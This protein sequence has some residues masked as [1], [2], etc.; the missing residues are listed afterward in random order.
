M[1]LPLVELFIETDVKDGS[2][3]TAIATVDNPA[4]DQDYFAFKAA[5]KAKTIRINLA[6]NKGDFAPVDGDKQILAGALMIPEVN[7]YRVD[8]ETKKEYNVKF[9]K[10]TIEQI[11]KKF[12]KLNLSNNINQ[13]HDN[14]K[15]IADSYLFQSIIINRAIG[16]NPPLNQNQLPDGTWFGFIQIGDKKVW[17]EFIKTGIYKGFSVEGNFYERQINTELTE[18]QAE[19]IIKNLFS[20]MSNV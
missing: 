20:E 16:V 15:I 14:N 17:D 4:I 2:G 6:S 9:T 7:I 5:N 1:E 12:A 10:E 19:F 3:V 11:V 8:E 13:M 18:Q